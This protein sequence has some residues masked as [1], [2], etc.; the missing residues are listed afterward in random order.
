M[1]PKPVVLGTGKNTVAF[2]ISE[3]AWQ[4]DAQFTISVDGKQ[5]GGTQTATASRN[6]GQAQ[7]FNVMGDFG[8]GNHVATVNFLNDAYN[9]TASTDRNLYVGGA[10]LDG[11]AVSGSALA[12]TSAGPQ[13]F[14][15]AGAASTATDMLD[16]HVSEDAWQGDAQFTIM[17]DGIAVGGTRSTT[18][19]HAAG[20]SQDFLVPGNWGDG[21]HNIGIAFVNDAWGGTAATDRN[22]YIDQATYNGRAVSGAPASLQSNGTANLG[23]AAAA[24]G[25]AAALT[26]HLAEDAWRGD[27]QY[28]VSLDGKVLLSGATV[29]ASN[30]LGQS[31][32]INL[33]AA[34]S[35][36]KHDLSIA[37]LN[38]AYGGAAGTDRNFF[39]KGIDLNGAPVSGSTAG[40]YSNGVASFQ[41]VVGAPA[42]VSPPVSVPAPPP[43]PAP[44][45]APVPVPVPAPAP[46]PAP[47]GPGYHVAVGGNDSNLGDAAHPFATLQRAA[48]AMASSGVKTT[49][50]SGGAYSSLLTLGRADSGESFIAEGSQAVTLKGGGTMVTINGSDHVTLSGLSFTGTSGPAVV[51]DGG[52]YNTVANS[53]FTANYGGVLLRNGASHDTIS[54][55]TMTNTAF[56][57][58]E[59][60]DGSNWNTVSGNLIDGVGPVASETYGGAIYLHGSS[61]DQLVHNEIRNTAGAGINLSDFTYDGSTANLNNV[62]LGNKLLNTDL[63]STDSGA[64]YI[65]GRSNAATNTLVKTNLVDGAGRADQHSVGIYLDDNT[66]GVAVQGNILRNV[67]SDA[68]QIHGGSDNHVTGNVFDL[69]IGHSSAV[70]FQAGPAD[71]PNPSP[72][73][74]NSVTGNIVYSQSDAPGSFYVSLAGGNPAVSGNDYYGKTGVALNVSPDTSAKYQNPEFTSAPSGN[75]GVSAGAGI[76][77]ASIDQSQIGLYPAST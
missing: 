1:S 47:A 46:A 7:A 26:L 22:L 63:T 43:V 41:I 45:P 48:A 37:F 62:I 55:N 53:T 77:F 17:V 9:G 71:Q 42:P 16:L 38:D 66:S 72:L 68:V 31:Q 75:Y 64:I 51:I 30:A 65:L 20:A 13:S 23:V 27:A 50:V 44:V 49:M 18:A 60:K 29:T 56:A 58:I 10:T 33:Q 67:G 74:D 12:L 52:S 34:L 2:S 76:G 14:S 61:N 28:S 19:S 4:G 70:L 40:L 8:P 36:G 54:N 11:A 25:A 32:A 57:G 6:A 24:S 3:D 15:F 59:I 35:P 21:P 39:I 73:R 69:G 5:V